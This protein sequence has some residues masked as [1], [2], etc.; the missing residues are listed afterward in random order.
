M[1]VYAAEVGA[2][3]CMSGKLNT[4]VPGSSMST[5]ERVVVSSRYGALFLL[6][7]V[8]LLHRAAS[9]KPKGRSTP[10]LSS[11]QPAASPKPSLSWIIRTWPRL[12]LPAMR[13]RAPGAHPP[14]C[15]ARPAGRRAARSPACMHELGP[16]SGLPYC[17]SSS[18]S[19]LTLK[20]RSWFLSRSL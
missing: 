11:L 14:P 16:L 2:A 12:Q 6:Q 9:R 19:D 10:P 15:G 17:R 5:A 20:L 8:M 1:P 13:R 18:T 3:V 4:M 7:S